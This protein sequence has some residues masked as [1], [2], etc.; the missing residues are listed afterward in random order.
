MKE[1]A[2]K[3]FS[4]LRPKM[5]E[6][7]LN[8]DGHVLLYRLI[9]HANEDSALGNCKQNK[10]S[11]SE[12][13]LVFQGMYEFASGL[14]LYSSVVDV[15]MVHP[16][17]HKLERECCLHIHKTELMDGGAASCKHICAQMCYQQQGFSRFVKHAMEWPVG[18]IDVCYI[19]RLSA[20]ARKGDSG[21]PC[22]SRIRQ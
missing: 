8:R 9:L 18:L 17:V 2:R 21:P 14:L 20:L 10:N 12:R 3:L 11:L 22:V 7:C 1:L 15:K 16:Y 19:L 5:Y 4:R 13:C 6:Q